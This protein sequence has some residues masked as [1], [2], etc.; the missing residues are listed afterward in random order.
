MTA[1]TVPAHAPVRGITNECSSEL[2]S[3]SSHFHSL[4]LG[5]VEMCGESRAMGRARIVRITA[6]M[7]TGLATSS[8][9]QANKGL[10]AHQFQFA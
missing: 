1:R 2:N 7:R 6:F 10:V 4:Y 3:Q 5:W 8:G 9:L